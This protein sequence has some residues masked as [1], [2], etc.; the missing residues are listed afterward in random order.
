MFRDKLNNIVNF[1]KKPRNFVICAKNDKII[2]IP[3]STLSM[4]NERYFDEFFQYDFVDCK[5][6]K[7][8]SYNIN[9]ILF[10]KEFKNRMYKS[11]IGVNSTVTSAKNVG[12]IENKNVVLVHN[13]LLQ[14]SKVNVRP[15]K[16]PMPNIQCVD[17]LKLAD[18]SIIVA[19]N[20]TFKKCMHTTT[21][22]VDS[23]DSTEHSVGVNVNP[24][25]VKPHVGRK[26]NS[27]KAKFYC[28]KCEKFVTEQK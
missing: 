20:N 23:E 5:E 19:E 14:D 4:I 13:E 21:E 8:V 12:Q 7:K 9:N 1:I 2:F 27:G 24:T 15:S 10:M 16:G 28:S 26:T 11:S 3:P 6:N 17:S 25:G 22:P 18:G